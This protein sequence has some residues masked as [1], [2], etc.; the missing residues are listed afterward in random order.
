MRD[1]PKNYQLALHIDYLDLPNTIILFIIG[2]SKGINLI[3]YD[4]SIDY[5]MRPT[6]GASL[7]YKKSPNKFVQNEPKY[8]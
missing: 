2:S 7:T 1:G 8:Y 5:L 6:T 4:Q 3:M